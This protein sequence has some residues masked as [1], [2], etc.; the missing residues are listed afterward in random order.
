MAVII[1]SDVDGAVEEVAGAGD[2]EDKVLIPLGALRENWTSCSRS[3]KGRPIPATTL[4][5]ESNDQ[6]LGVSLRPTPQQMAPIAVG[7]RFTVRRQRCVLQRGRRLP[8]GARTL[9]CR[10]QEGRPL[11][12]LDS[13]ARKWGESNEWNG[14]CYV[15]LYGSCEICVGRLLI[16]YDMLFSYVYTIFFF[17]RK[18]RFRY[19]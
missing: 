19:S 11:R 6:D 14:I 8:N 1:A 10:R 18:L 4:P 16:N 15:S 13:M 9:P 5:M 3:M 7:D 12:R 17:L 2:V